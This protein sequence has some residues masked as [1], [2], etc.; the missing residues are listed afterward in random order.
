MTGGNS[1]I[2]KENYFETGF[3]TKDELNLF[4][5]LNRISDKLWAIKFQKI[6]NAVQEANA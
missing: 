6:R 5:E 1:M 2:G 3:I 4:I